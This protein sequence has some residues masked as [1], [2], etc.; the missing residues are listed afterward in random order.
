MS[1]FLVPIDGSVH[2]FKALD[3]ACTLAKI[4]DSELLLTY[5]CAPS[6]I[7]QTSPDI[8]TADFGGQLDKAF[9]DEG[10]PELTDSTINSEL[11]NSIILNH[12]RRTEV[13]NKAIGKRTLKKAIEKANIHGIQQAKESILI[14]KPAEEILSLSEKENVD[15]IV[16]GTRGLGALSGVIAGSVSQAILHNATCSVIVVK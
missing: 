15:T 9:L 11:T 5:V 7:I 12:V 1:K 3:I 6:D 13:I 14:G 8:L 4:N 10:L 2:S 16:L